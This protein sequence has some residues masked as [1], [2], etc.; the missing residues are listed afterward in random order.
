MLEK[1]NVRHRACG[2]PLAAPRSTPKFPFWPLARTWADHP[3]RPKAVLGQFSQCAAPCFLAAAAQGE[4][5]WARRFQHAAGAAAAQ[6]GVVGLRCGP[7]RSALSTSPCSRSP[8]P[9]LRCCSQHA[10]TAARQ[11]G[12]LHGP[13]AARQASASARAST[14]RLRMAHTPREVRPP[15]SRSAAAAATHAQAVSD[16]APWPVV[17]PRLRSPCSEG[18]QQCRAAPGR[19]RMGLT[20][21]D[22]WIWTRWRRLWRQRRRRTQHMSLEMSR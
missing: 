19:R 15:R 11:V 5:L 20:R 3:H 7:T 17:G 9:A 8:L 10:S 16:Q 6:R 2:P 22:P 12:L 13:S 21:L 18:A 4:R 14:S 1:G